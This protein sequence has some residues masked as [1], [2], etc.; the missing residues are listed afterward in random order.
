M[1]ASD[2][3]VSSK[4]TQGDACPWDLGPEIRRM[5]CVS[6][7]MSKRRR[8]NSH[9]NKPVPEELR[10]LA[11][12]CPKCLCP[13]KIRHSRFG[14]FFGCSR[15]PPCR[16]IRTPDNACALAEFQE[17]V[18]KILLP[19]LNSE[20]ILFNPDAPSHVWYGVHD[21]RLNET[22]A[23]MEAQ[24]KP[25]LRPSEDSPTML[26]ELEAVAQKEV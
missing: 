19:P 6:N 10:Q 14:P 9:Q 2:F 4:A 15:Y 21:I 5:V 3:P 25:A 17:V 7:N 26:Q 8:N 24:P 16:G 11:V 1:A 13:M 12:C 18:E 20:E 22:T 23:T